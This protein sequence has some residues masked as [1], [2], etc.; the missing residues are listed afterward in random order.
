MVVAVHWQQLCNDQVALPEYLPGHHPVRFFVPQGDP[1]S[2]IKFDFGAHYKSDSAFLLLIRNTNRNLS[3]TIAIWI[4][5][6][7]LF[8]Y[9]VVCLI[10]LLP[11]C[12]M[13]PLICLIANFL[14]GELP[15]LEA[16]CGIRR[17]ATELVT[18]KIL[19]SCSG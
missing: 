11:N 1:K 6:C 13:R 7:G 5:E 16:A 3:E 15:V 19:C 17:L 18:G 14:T 12:A 10:W 2:E 4:I 9:L 8:H